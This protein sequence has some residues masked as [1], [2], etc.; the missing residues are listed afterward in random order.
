MSENEENLEKA[1][2][3]GVAAAGGIGGVSNPAAGV[4][5]MNPS[6]NYG[7][8]TGPNAVNPSGVAGGIPSSLV[9]SLTMFGT[10]QF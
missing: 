9:N 1:V 2:A 3:S 8:T 6:A 10:Q 5:G 7:V 4:L